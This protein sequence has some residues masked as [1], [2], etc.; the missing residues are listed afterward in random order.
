[1]EKYLIELKE[2]HPDGH[3]PGWYFH[4]ESGDLHG[5]YPSR[6]KALEEIEIYCE[7][8]DRHI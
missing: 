3:V 4:D 7:W 8:L 1:M 6:E 5:P 2:P